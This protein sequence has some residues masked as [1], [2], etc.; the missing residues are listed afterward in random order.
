MAEI[1][2]RRRI[3]GERLNEAARLQE[4]NARRSFARMV[5]DF[6]RSRGAMMVPSD[7]DAD[8]SVKHEARRAL[9][10]LDH[11]LNSEP[12]IVRAREAARER[13][14]RAL[15]GGQRAADG[16]SFP[17]HLETSR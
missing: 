6:E 8:A 14:E 7:L 5:A 4:R 16:P 3:D 2:A 17:S 13:F 1:A 11:R 12:G 10:Q 15:L 9:A